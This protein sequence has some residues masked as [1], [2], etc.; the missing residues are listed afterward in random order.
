MDSYDRTDSNIEGNPYGDVPSQRAREADRFRETYMGE[1]SNGIVSTEQA[2]GMF[3]G[4]PENAQKRY[5]D[6]YIAGQPLDR[7]GNVR[8][9]SQ[10]EIKDAWDNDVVSAAALSKA[11]GQ[12][13]SPFNMRLMT[14]DRNE[15]YLAQLNSAGSGSGAYMGPTRTVENRTNVNLSDPSQS[16]SLLESAMTQYLGRRP[17]DDERNEFIKSLNYQQTNNPQT[18]RTVTKSSGRSLGDANRKVS[19]DSVN[20]S[21]LDSRQIAKEYAMSRSDFAETQMATNGKKMVMN[22]LSGRS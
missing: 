11:T 13:M 20:S 22:I 19:S 10:K 7:D 6:S 5:T 9:P 18:S 16:R 14:N 2:Q 17:R 3:F 12:A 4:M 15:S 21:G 8:L 1:G